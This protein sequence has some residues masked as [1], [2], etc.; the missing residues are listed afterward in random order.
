[1]QCGIK[2]YQQLQ[3]HY[4]SD[5][6]QCHSPRRQNHKRI[7]KSAFVSSN[8]F[9]LFA[10]CSCIVFVGYISKLICLGLVWHDMSHVC[11]YLYEDSISHIPQG[12]V[13]DMDS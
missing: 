8:L 4:V 11:I 12:T 6:C 10:F 9:L 2:I 5:N 7:I 1:M 13:H 3:S